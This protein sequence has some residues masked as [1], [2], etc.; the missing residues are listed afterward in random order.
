MQSNVTG[1]V[2]AL[3]EVGKGGSK[4]ETRVAKCEF[5]EMMKLAAATV[6]AAVG[7]KC[8]NPRGREFLSYN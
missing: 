2:A 3:N 5:N 6:A 7:A 4:D 1:N 8:S